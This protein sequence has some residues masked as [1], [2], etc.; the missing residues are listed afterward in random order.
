MNMATATNITANSVGTA[1][2]NVE[3]NASIFRLWTGGG[4]SSEYFLIE[5]RRRTGYDTYLPGEGLLIWHIDE[6]T[7]S[8]TNEWYPGN[9]SSGN[10]KVALEQADGLWNVEKKIDAGSVGDPF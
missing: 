7:A 1:I 5:N 4:A 10:F 3:N 9:T 6:G 2:P 8:N